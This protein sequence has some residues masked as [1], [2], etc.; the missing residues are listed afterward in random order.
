LIRGDR[1]ESAGRVLE[2]V[3]DGLGL[4]EELAKRRVLEY[5]NEAVGGDAA[6]HSRAVGITREGVLQVEV[7]HPAWMQEL[8]FLEEEILQRLAELAG[9]GPVR[10]LRLTH[11]RRQP[12]EELGEQ[13]SDERGRG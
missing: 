4:T 13:G 12:G 11:R 5:W 10:G 9:G 8:K 3:L 7:D 6:A 1:V 2:R